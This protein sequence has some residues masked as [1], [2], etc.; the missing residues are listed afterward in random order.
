MLVPRSRAA[1]G[2]W[3]PSSP[4]AAG[5]RP[6]SRNTGPEWTAGRTHPPLSAGHTSHRSL[7]AAG[8]W[9]EDRTGVPFKCVSLSHKEGR[10][11]PPA[12]LRCLWTAKSPRAKPHNHTTVCTRAARVSVLQSRAALRRCPGNN[13]KRTQQVPERSRQRQVVQQL[14]TSR[15]IHSLLRRIQDPR[16]R[17]SKEVIC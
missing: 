14:C 5:S 10:G 16:L 1:P 17:S 15:T 6:T 13:P 4:Q 8:R 2:P 12:V 3:P 7:S 11:F 9:H